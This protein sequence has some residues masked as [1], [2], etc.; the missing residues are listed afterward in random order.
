M[1]FRR[2]SLI[3]G[4]LAALRKEQYACLR[5]FAATIDCAVQYSIAS[6]GD[7]NVFI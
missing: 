5:T 1:E 3:L 4:V 2:G 7:E 6:R